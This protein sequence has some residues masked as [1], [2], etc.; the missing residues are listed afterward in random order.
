MPCSLHA[1][2]LRPVPTHSP[3]LP[4]RMVS[5]PFC[6]V[7]GCSM[8][9][10]WVQG[11]HHNNYIDMRI[12]LHQ[13]LHIQLHITAVHSRPHRGCRMVMLWWDVIV[14]A[15]PS[16][17]VPRFDSSAHSFVCYIDRDAQGRQGMDRTAKAQINQAQ[18][19]NKNQPRG[20]TSPR[21]HAGTIN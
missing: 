10:V 13:A 11:A 14:T 15:V 20:E 17:L 2:S 8:Q 5:E 1:L 6:T 19:G 4:V 18:N 7:A 16:C 12:M 3:R 9:L 21:E